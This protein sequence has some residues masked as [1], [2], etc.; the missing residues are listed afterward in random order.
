M[1]AAAATAEH[2]RKIPTMDANTAMPLIGLLATAL[3]PDEAHLIVGWSASS[4]TP[5]ME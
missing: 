4:G 2:A 1:S 5:R 3:R